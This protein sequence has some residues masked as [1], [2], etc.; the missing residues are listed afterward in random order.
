[1]ITFT[2]NRVIGRAPITSLLLSAVLLVLSACGTAVAP[3]PTPRSDYKIGLVLNEGGTIR[4]G[5]FNESAYNGVL[6]VGKDFGVDVAYKETISGKDYAAAIDTFVADG[7]NII[8]T[9]GFQMIEATVQSAQKYP[10]AKFIGVDFT[11]DPLPPNFT[12]LLFRE[13][14]GGFLAGALAGLMTKSNT[15][16]VIGGQQIPPV[17][18]FVKGFINGVTYTNRDAKPLFKYSTSFNNAEE[19]RLSA[20]EFI[21]Q[22]ADVIFGAGGFTGSSAIAF[23]ASQKVYV[24]GVDQDEFGTTFALGRDAEYILTSAV[25]RVDTAVFNSVREILDGKFTASSKVLG[26]AQCGV[27]F[28]PYHKAEAAVAQPTRDKLEAIWR[29]LAGG[30]LNTGASDAGDTP[31]ASLNP[32]DNPTVDANAPKYADCF[33]AS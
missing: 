9:V 6:L 15:V 3:T 28:A 8:V 1:M 32:G 29:A 4:D 26:A 18:R 11:L 16:A 22:G 25:K 2:S 13:D 27:T 14:E 21:T 31:P 30:T 20:Q 19:G 10:N 33:R 17:E 5:G 7:R 12:G 24:I 23:A